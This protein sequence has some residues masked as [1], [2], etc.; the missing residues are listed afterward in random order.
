MNPSERIVVARDA[1][2][3]IRSTRDIGDVIGTC[4]GARLLLAED[5]LSA[6]FFDLRTGLAGEFL[7]KLVNYQIRTAI[8][9]AEPSLHGDRI[10]ELAREHRSH[11]VIRFV[12]DEAGALA[13]LKG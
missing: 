13:W 9:V 12:G 11:P 10:V 5:D 3:A 4:L 1:G 6:E 7:Q 2:L 8:I